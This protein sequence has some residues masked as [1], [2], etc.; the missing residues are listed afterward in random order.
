MSKN[1]KDKSN[2]SIQLDSEISNGIYSN[3]VIINHSASEFV[4]DFV[5]FKI[6][7][8]FTH[9]FPNLNDFL[10]RRPLPPARSSTFPTYST[11]I[12]SNSDE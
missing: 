1:L 12:S 8:V 3:L 11:L 9:M 5:C 6:F 7:H 2:I 10:A 4:F